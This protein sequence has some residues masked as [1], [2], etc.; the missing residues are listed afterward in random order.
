MSPLSNRYSPQD[1]DRIKTAIQFYI[2][3][4]TENL[5]SQNVGDREWDELECYKMILNDLIFFTLPPHA[6]SHQEN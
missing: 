5:S 2:D 4:E 3:C 1:W 6:D